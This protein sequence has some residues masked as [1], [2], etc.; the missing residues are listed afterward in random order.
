M[1]IFPYHIKTKIIINRPE[2]VS[3]AIFLETTILINKRVINCGPYFSLIAE[4]LNGFDLAMS[5]FITGEEL[6]ED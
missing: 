4:H 6:D 2:A 1:A 3:Y 5:I